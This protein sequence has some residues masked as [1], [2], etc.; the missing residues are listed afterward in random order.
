MYWKRGDL[1][2]E[3]KQYAIDPESVGMAWHDSKGW[4]GAGLILVT[5]LPTSVQHLQP[6]CSVHCGKK[7]EKL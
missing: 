7:M 5:V 2:K 1:P 6:P 3:L 4:D